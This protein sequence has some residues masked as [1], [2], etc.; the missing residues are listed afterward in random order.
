MIGFGYF[1]RF[2][3]TKFLKL[4][5]ADIHLPGL[6]IIANIK[7]KN[8]DVSAGYFLKKCKNAK[9]AAKQAASNIISITV[10]ANTKVLTPSLLKNS[11]IFSMA[12]PFFVNELF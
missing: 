5:F 3:F 1:P 11:L 12:Y 2:I 8:A 7:T 4:K 6:P 9:T 10:S